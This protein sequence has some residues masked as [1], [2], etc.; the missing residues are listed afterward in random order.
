MQGFFPQRLLNIKCVKGRENL[1]QT[2][3]VVISIQMV[4]SLC[5][6][7]LHT[8]MD[9]WK[10]CTRRYKRVCFLFVPHIGLCEASCLSACLA[11]GCLARSVGWSRAYTSLSAERTAAGTE[12]WRRQSRVT[13]L[14]WMSAVLPKPVLIAPEATNFFPHKI[15][16]S[17][18]KPFFTICQILRILSS[19][20][21]SLS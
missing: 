14:L 12:P 6:Y 7:S 13:E 8:V 1:I 3:R 16:I 17:T 21:M 2:R 18:R 4:H 15:F 19:F 5:H 11:W 9:A 10:S 20:L